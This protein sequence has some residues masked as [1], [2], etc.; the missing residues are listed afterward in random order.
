MLLLENITFLKDLP[1]M[2]QTTDHRLRVLI[3]EDNRL[4][5]MILQKILE[6]YQHEVIKA[7]NGE[8]AIAQAL[9][10]CPDI[11]FMDLHMPVLN[12][13]ESAIAIRTAFLA[14]G[15]PVPVIVAT[16]AYINEKEIFNEKYA[17]AGFERIFLKPFNTAELVRLLDEISC[18]K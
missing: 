10:Y 6:Q 16:T 18:V 1:S 17:A 14:S 7:T 12:G 4:T 15:K 8:D 3:A 2:I 5:Q 9:K 13:C 11:I